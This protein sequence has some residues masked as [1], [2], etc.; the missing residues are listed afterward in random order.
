[1]KRL[2]T[3]ALWSAAITAVSGIGLFAGMSGSTAWFAL[4]P[5]C[6]WLPGCI[7]RFSSGWEVEPTVRV[8]HTDVAHY[9]LTFLVWWGFLFALA[10]W[11]SRQDAERRQPT[12]RN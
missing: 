9:V 1:M 2:V 12:Q 6:S 7:W 3:C 8:L 11:A 4:P 5:T 10:S